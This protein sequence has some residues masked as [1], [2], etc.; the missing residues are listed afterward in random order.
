MSDLKEYVEKRKQA[1]P[2]FARDYESGYENFKIGKMLK[3]ARLER[4]LTQEELATRLHTKK[5]AISRIENHAE[6]IRLSTLERYAR[7]LDKELRVAI[8]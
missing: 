8:G 2:E 3:Q 6:D 4:G 5:T 1:D 7:A